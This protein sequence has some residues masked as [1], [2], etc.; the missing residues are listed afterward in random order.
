MRSASAASE[1][2]SW[3]VKLEVP[4]NHRRKH[5][6]RSW[7]KSKVAQRPRFRWTRW[8]QIRP[9]RPSEAKIVIFPILNN[10]HLL[11]FKVPFGVIYC[12]GLNPTSEVVRG[13]LRLFEAVFRK[14]CIWHF[15]IMSGRIEAIRGRFW[16]SCIWHLFIISGRIED[17]R[18]CF[19][20]SCTW[21]FFIIS[22]QIEAVTVVTSEA[23]WGQKSFWK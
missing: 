19:L 17:I 3:Y 14:R 21:H 4:K 22:G 18:G 23:T 11:H 7:L 5:F 20:K 2:V 16:K 15:F 1:A 6:S 12:C 9:P 8:P 10:D 13:R